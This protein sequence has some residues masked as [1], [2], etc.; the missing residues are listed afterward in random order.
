MR[1]CRQHLNSTPQT[2]HL[3]TISHLLNGPHWY[4]LRTVAWSKPGTGTVTKKRSFCFPLL[5]FSNS[6]TPSL[7][8]YFFI[9]L[10]SSS[11]SCFFSTP[12]APPLPPLTSLPSAFWYR[13]IKHR[14]TFSLEPGNEA[15]LW[16]LLDDFHTCACAGVRAAVRVCVRESAAGGWQRHD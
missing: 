4:G 14:K 13:C 16:P 2:L 15:D 6:T 11:S 5:H 8:S 7:F 9:K 12:L 1:V 10:K 3:T